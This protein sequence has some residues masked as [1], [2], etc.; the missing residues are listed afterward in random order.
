MHVRRVLILG[1]A[2]A[3]VAALA[4][5]GADRWAGAASKSSLGFGHEVVVD[6]QR[7]DGEPSLSISPTLNKAHQ[8]DIYV[9][10][11]YGFSTSASFLWKSEDGGK[12]FHLVGDEN[13]AA[14]GKPAT[15]CAGGGDSS[16]VN[17]SAGNLYF[18]DLQGLT[19]VSDSVSTDGGN[20]FTT[21]CN[22]A[23]AAG[24]DRP[25][26]AVYKN[27]LTTGRE[28]MTVDDVEACDPDTCGLGQTGANIVELTQASGTGAQT[29]T[30]SPLPAQQIEPDGIVGGI[31]VNQHTGAVYIAHTA[32]TDGKGRITGGGDANGNDNA[33]VVDSFPKGY[34]QTTPTPI[35]VGSI[36]VC[37]PYNTSGP[38]TSSTVVHSPLN[39]NGDSTVNN[40]QDFAPIA[41]DKS[42]NLYVVWAQSPVNASGATDGPTTVYLSTSSNGGK[43]WTKPIDV[44][45]SVPGLRTNVFPW[46]AAGSKGRIDVVWYG[47]KT[48]GNCKK[49]CGAGFINASWNV[50]MAQSL[51]TVSAQGKANSSPSFTAKK[52][53]EYPNHYG[54]ICEF[55]IACATGGDRGLIDFIQVQALPNGAAAIV[56]ADGA[57]TDFNGGETSPVIGYAQQTKGPSLYAGHTIRAAKPRFGSA[58]GSKASY[59]AAAGSETK[60]GGNMR[61]LNS[62]VKE[63]GKNY[64]VTM[65]VKSLASL[66]PSPALGGTD[67]I[68]LTRWETRKG[69]PSTANQGHVFFAAM[70]SDGGGK[71]SFY[72]GETA[73]GVPPSNPEEHCKALTYGPGKTIKGRYTKKGTIRLVVPLKDVGGDRKLFSVTGVTA[74]QSTPGS[75]G[76]TVFNVIDST[77]PYDVR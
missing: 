72:V 53:T 23:N 39:K 49:G 65:K 8:H 16:I 48:L 2:A 3:V 70:E 54:S 45:G 26:L 47:T 41:I 6:Y 4:A 68:W 1:L 33:I 77:A 69:K 52:V 55:G 19:N 61:I 35:P 21:T 28:Y 34:S 56:W 51:N 12:S 75:S 37:K 44:S 13:P 73:C 67:A 15:T 32:F 14:L 74:T 62:S 64:I 29:Q 7:V 36:S 27:P 30:F 40:G 59:Y 76:G 24:V 57:N 22:T 10:A 63:K 9:S 17:D 31:V 20:S 58:S 38:C 43:T 11:P 50:Y 66:S 25:W 5:V 71:P 60:A 42:G 46:V 18:A